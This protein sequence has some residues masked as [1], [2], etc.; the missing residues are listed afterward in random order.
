CFDRSR[1]THDVNNEWND[2]Q[3]DNRRNDCSYRPTRPRYENLLGCRELHDQRIGHHRCNEHRTRD[4]GA[5]VNGEREE[6]AC[7]P[8]FYWIVRERFSR[9]RLHDR[10]YNTGGT[11]RVAWNRGRKDKIRCNEAVPKTQRA[12]TEL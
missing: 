8:S 1:R 10:K 11:S 2:D 5:F 3:T 7:F 12:A 6:R 4:D 9:N